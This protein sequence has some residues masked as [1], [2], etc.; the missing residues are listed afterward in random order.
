MIAGNAKRTAEKD[1]TAIER[2]GKLLVKSI[3]A[4]VFTSGGI[5]D[6]IIDIIFDITTPYMVRNTPRIM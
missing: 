3:G 4:G 2:S 1:S 6:G 5:I